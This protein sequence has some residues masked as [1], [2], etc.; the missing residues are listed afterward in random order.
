MLSLTC[1]GPC[2]REPT[3]PPTTLQRLSPISGVERIANLATALRARP[4]LQEQSS[5]CSTCGKCKGYRSASMHKVRASSSSPGSR[6]AT[7]D[8]S[9]PRSPSACLSCPATSFKGGG[10]ASGRQSFPPPAFCATGSRSGAVT[11]C[12]GERM[13]TKAAIRKPGPTP[14]LNPRGPSEAPTGSAQ[15][16]PA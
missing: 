5:E 6:E 14:T 1:T 11:P 12:T 16:A 2:N 15:L 3:K 4:Q 9:G 7:C 13:A 8:A 10:G